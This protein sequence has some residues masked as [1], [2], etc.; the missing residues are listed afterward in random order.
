MNIEVLEYCIDIA[1]C[2]SFTETARKYYITQQALSQQIRNLEK[3]LGVQLYVRGHHRF[4]VTPA[5]AAFIQEAEL[6][7]AHYNNGVESARKF[8]TGEKGSITC[9]YNG[10]S[11]EHYLT[12]VLDVFSS[13][14]PDIDV[15]IGTGTNQEVHEQF[16]RNQFDVIAVG[17][18][19]DF[20]PEVYEV[21]GM[22]QGQLY[23]VVGKDHPLAEKGEISGTDL[24]EE[25]YISLDFK[26]APE[27]MRKSLDR[28][29][30][31]LGYTPERI[32]YARNTQTLDLLVGS[33]RGYTMLSG[34]L[35]GFYRNATLRF[36]KLTGEPVY[37]ESR[38]ISRR[39][40][41]NPAVSHFLAIAQKLREENERRRM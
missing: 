17:D 37:H 6:A 38:L 11:A 4:E 41:P 10:P 2:G 20:D 23:A 25:T 21:K 15:V 9:G 3:S 16:L 33:G 22:I 1:R 14:Y 19:M 7:L 5:G 8:A 40:N 34:E 24:A 39:D 13:A 26:E 30:R 27:M 36:L 32:Q 35:Q 28:V 18:F 29:T 31:A 12:T